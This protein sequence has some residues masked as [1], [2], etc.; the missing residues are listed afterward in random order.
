MTAAVTADDLAT[1][2]DRMRFESICSRIAKIREIAAGAH[3]AALNADGKAVHV[4][5]G[6][7]AVI[8]IDAIDLASRLGMKDADP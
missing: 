5:L 2:L 6:K 7:A 1:T 3:A 8:L 4:S